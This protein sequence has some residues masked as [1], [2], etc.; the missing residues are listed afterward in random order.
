[1]CSSDLVLTSTIE[2]ILNPTW[3]FLVLGEKPGKWALIGGVIVIV[4]VIVRGILST[5]SQA[6]QGERKA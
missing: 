3:V 2:P 4:T 5:R 1:V 6:E